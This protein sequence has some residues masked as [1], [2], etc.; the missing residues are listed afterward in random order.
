MPTCW[1]QL[2][3]SNTLR[4]RLTPGINH[5]RFSIQRNRITIWWRSR[6]SLVLT[7]RTRMR[8][9]CGDHR[10]S[11]G[12]SSTRGIPSARNRVSIQPW[13]S[14]QRGK[15]KCWIQ[16]M[17]KRSEPVLDTKRGTR[18]ATWRCRVLETITRSGI[19]RFLLKE[20]KSS[21]WINNFTRR[22]RYMVKWNW[23]KLRLGARPSGIRSSI[24]I[25]SRH[26]RINKA[27]L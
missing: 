7:F 3:K 17:A 4:S 25:W 14:F 21:G 26:C 2:T 20:A 16:S 18:C 9:I 6:R 23:I 11:K 12:T 27:I 1:V 24:I 5:H 8:S 13:W 19:R 22:S 10:R 15:R